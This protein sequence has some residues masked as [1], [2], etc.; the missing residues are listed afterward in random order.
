MSTVGIKELKNRLTAYLRR[1]RQGEEVIVTQ[2][3]KPI[4]LIQPIQS[5][6]APVSLEARLVKLASQGRIRLPSRR[7]LKKIRRVTV[8]G[9]PISELILE[10][11]R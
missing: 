6:T 1:T 7:P 3:G 2:R 5:S 10:D 11:R 4:A 8:S 9:R